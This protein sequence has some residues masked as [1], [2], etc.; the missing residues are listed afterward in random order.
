MV[1]SVKVP[2]VQAP[3]LPSGQ[4]LLHASA[5]RRAERPSA[6]RPCAAAARRARAES[7][8]AIVRSPCGS[9]DQRRSKL[10]EDCLQ[11]F[12]TDGLF[13]RARHGEAESLAQPERR[14]EHAAVEAADDQDGGTIILLG[15]E[16]KQF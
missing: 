11:V 8:R 16:P 15:K 1:R 12:E 2:R 13:D 7:L 10:V 3:D 6:G 9:Y 5:D 4:A 14:F